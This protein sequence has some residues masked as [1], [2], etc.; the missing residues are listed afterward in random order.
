MY[1]RFLTAAFIAMMALSQTTS[2]AGQ[3]SKIASEQDKQPAADDSVNTLQ[4]GLDQYGLTPTAMI[5]LE[6]LEKHLIKH[7]DQKVIIKGYTDNLG[8]Q[9]YNKRLS[10][11]R[12]RT[13]ATY[14]KKKGIDAER[15][16]AKG[17]GMQNPVADNSTEQGRKQN[18]RVTWT[19]APYEAASEE[20]VSQKQEP[21]RESQVQFSEATGQASLP[22]SYNNVFSGKG[23]PQAGQLLKPKLYFSPAVTKYM[24]H[25]LKSQL[26]DL[27]SILEKHPEVG[28]KIHAHADRL[29]TNKFN[30]DKIA[31]ER[32]RVVRDYLTNQG[33]AA[34]RI[35]VSDHG[36]H[37]A[38]ANNFNY[39]NRRVVFE[40]VE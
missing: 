9:S 17:Y 2:F 24:T 40:V 3:P 12:T 13:V 32:A 23:K 11:H 36:A 39:K 19:F 14:L 1:T 34:K 27:V 21:S 16:T 7:P 29:N 31:K 8:P 38:L 10:Q 26:D 22:Y 5:K 4:F 15:I 25:E 20:V 35:Q 28:I 18:R 30:S 6:K 33:I 37:Y